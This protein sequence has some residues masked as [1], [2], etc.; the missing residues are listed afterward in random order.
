MPTCQGL[1]EG[2]KKSSVRVK[3]LRVIC[4]PMDPEAF[5]S[6]R[7]AD[8]LTGSGPGLRDSLFSEENG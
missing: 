5:S 4:D 1:G 6:V 2:G 8:T 7:S 3:A